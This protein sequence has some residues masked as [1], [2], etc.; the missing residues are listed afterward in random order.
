MIK[1]LLPYYHAKP[2]PQTKAQ[3]FYNL[4][5]QLDLNKAQRLLLIKKMFDR[6]DVMSKKEIKDTINQN[7]Q[8]INLL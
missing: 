3:Y 2:L 7:L 6:L 1:T 5:Y 8:N 4:M